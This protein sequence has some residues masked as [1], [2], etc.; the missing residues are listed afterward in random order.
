MATRVAWTAEQDARLNAL[1]ASGLTWDAVAASLGLRRNT[2][3]ERGRRIGARRAPPCRPP[4]EDPNRGPRCPGHPETWGLLIRGTLL[5][6]TPYPYP[7]F[8]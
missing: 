2:V 1:R 8:L 5:E 3:H 7:V 6:G 4:P